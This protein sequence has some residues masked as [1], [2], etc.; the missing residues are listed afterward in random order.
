[1]TQKQIYQKPAT[2]VFELKQQSQLLA[3]S[4]G[5]ENPSGFPL[6]DDPLASELNVLNP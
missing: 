6:E 1:M 5:L 3:G 2:Q 4:G